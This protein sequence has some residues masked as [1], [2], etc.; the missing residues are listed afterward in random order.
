MTPMQYELNEAR[1][2]RL[3]RM[4]GIPS[5]VV[6]L[7]RV[8]PSD[9][10]AAKPVENPEPEPIGLIPIEE[11][12]APQIKEGEELRIREIQQ[13]V[14]IRYRIGLEAIKS[15]SRSQFVMLPR[16]IAYTLARRLTGKS[17]ATIGRAFGGRDHTT[18]L[19]GVQRIEERASTDT[20]FA[21]ELEQL[22]QVIIGRSNLPCPCC[23]LVRGAPNDSPA[24]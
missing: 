21:A 22:E 10:L 13:A 23:G 17:L 6:P 5:N 4:G 20:A 24:A 14:A 18:V 19:H 2:E 1:K 15:D 16:Q 8:R 11:I 7:D 12:P 3:Q 9:S